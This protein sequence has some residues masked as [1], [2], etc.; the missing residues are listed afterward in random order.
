V[1]IINMGKGNNARDKSALTH[2]EAYLYGILQM[3][4][5]SEACELMLMADQEPGTLRTHFLTSALCASKIRQV[6]EAETK[7]KPI[8]PSLISP[9]VVAIL[10][11][12]AQDEEAKRD[13][14][15]PYVTEMLTGAYDTRAQSDMDALTT[16][17]MTGLDAWTQREIEIEFAMNR[18]PAYHNWK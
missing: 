14:L 2:E 15:L 7:G 18:P 9:T 17:E 12:V 3:F 13:N 16:R 4:E 5:E 6:R 11:Y 10:R 8:E 1:A